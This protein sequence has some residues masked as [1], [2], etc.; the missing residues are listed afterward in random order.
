MAGASSMT[1][2]M[3]GLSGIQST[4][5]KMLG[6]LRN[7]APAFHRIDKH[8]SLMFRRQFASEG[9]FGG[10]PWK[11]LAPSTIRARQ[12]PGRGRGGILRDSNTLWSS[13]VHTG[14]ESIRL[15][16]PDRYTRGTTVP[17]AASH[18]DGV[19]RTR[20]TRT[21]KR[22]GP[23]RKYVT[24]KMRRTS[25]PRRPI[26]PDPMPEHI[27]RTWEKILADYYAGGKP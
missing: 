1:F 25:L 2:K 17:Y 14:P 15:I 6:T 7:A 9:R 20:R 24:K 3:E 10:T 4:L 16:E 11:P 22:T 5:D 12:K 23:R 18:Q 8:V 26:I 21:G 19:K 27:S 13:L